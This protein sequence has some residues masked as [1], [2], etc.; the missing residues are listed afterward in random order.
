MA[1]SR[2]PWGTQSLNITNIISYDHGAL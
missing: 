2:T 1:L